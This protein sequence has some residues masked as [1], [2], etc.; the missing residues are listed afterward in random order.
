MRTSFLIVPAAAVTVLA[1]L[2]APAPA[3]AGTEDTKMKV[4]PAPSVRVELFTG[5]RE[6]AAPAGEARVVEIRD[7]PAPGWPLAAATAIGS[8]LLGSRPDLSTAWFAEDVLIRFAPSPAAGAGEISVAVSFEDLEGG[9]T[10][11]ETVS[12][13][14]GA[15]AAVV[16]QRG[17]STRAIG[18]RLA[19]SAASAEAPARWA[20][21][22]KSDFFTLFSTEGHWTEPADPAAPRRFLDSEVRIREKGEES[23]LLRAAE[24]EWRP[25][26]RELVARGGMLLDRAGTRLYAGDEI[27][28]YLSADRVEYG[29]QR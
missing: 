12:L 22:Y 11:D 7:L 17:G 29:A 19:A 6:E 23:Y 9:R 26:Q 20:M 16:F 18:V 28:L 25:R 15:P 1:L 21:V 13:A 5:T 27:F 3:A 2:S 10:Y 8:G 24:V 4:T 14:P